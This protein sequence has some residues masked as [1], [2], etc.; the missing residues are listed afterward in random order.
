MK[1]IKFDQETNYINDFINITKELYNNKN[2]TESVNTIKQFLNNNHPLSKYFKLN[3]F[4]VYKN[5]KAVGRFII[6]EYPDDKKVCYLGFFECINDKKVSKFIFD[7]AY[8]FAKEK[9]YKKII[10]PV[11]ASFWNKYRLKINLFDKRPY[12]GEPYNKEYYYKMFLD[13]KYKVIEHY[14]SNIFEKVDESYNNP[15]FTAHFKEFT[16]LGYEIVKPKMKDF[17]KCIEEI[18]YLIMDL[19]STFPTFKPIDKE[20]FITIFSSYKKIINMNMVRMAY[21]KGQAVGFCISIPNYYN[22]VYQLSWKQPLHLLHI[23]YERKFP[24]EYI[25]PYLGASHEHKGL[26]KAIAYS[27]AEE[28]KKNNLPSINALIRDGNINLKYG[29]DK[30]TDQ[31]EYVLL[32]RNIK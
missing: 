8:N 13:N 17:D 32:E 30:I 20:D 28:L 14:V 16:K 6:T 29:E 15:K 21:Y 23:M 1:L 18:Y 27:I 19:Y 31:Y 4:L 26:G 7:E 25:M 5:D 12:T 2:N 11:D 9:N 10:G 22:R 24:R 3:K